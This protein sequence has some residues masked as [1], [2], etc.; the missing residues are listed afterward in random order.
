V[1]KERVRGAHSFFTDPLSI[2]YIRLRQSA[3][4]EITLHSNNM[5]VAMVW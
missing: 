4:P 1:I 5:L 3:R 2:R